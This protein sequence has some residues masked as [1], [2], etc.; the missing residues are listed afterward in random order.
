MDRGYDGNLPGSWDEIERILNWRPDD[1]TESYA[2]SII[3]VPPYIVQLA[4]S[5]D[6]TEQDILTA[7]KE[8]DQTT[9]PAVELWRRLQEAARQ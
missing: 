2:V 6:L 3:D 9:E 7:F 8:W 1:V 4:R 5:G